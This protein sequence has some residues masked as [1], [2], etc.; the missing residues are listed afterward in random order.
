M[1]KTMKTMGSS[2]CDAPGCMHGKVPVPGTSG[3]ESTAARLR[4]LHGVQLQVF[5]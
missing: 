3:Y 2:K 5:S 4:P 1:R